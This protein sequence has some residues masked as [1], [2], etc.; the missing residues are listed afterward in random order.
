MP[1]FTNA[2][3]HEP[4][5]D[6]VVMLVQRDPWL[7]GSTFVMEQGLHA[8]VSVTTHARTA[9]ATLAKSC[10]GVL[11]QLVDISFEIALGLV[12]MDNAVMLL[13]VC[14]NIGTDARVHTWWH[15]CFRMHV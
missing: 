1:L 8:L 9:N 13:T 6:V 10:F 15:A 7:L 3:T 11:E 14:A 12:D 4:L 5:Q 2:N